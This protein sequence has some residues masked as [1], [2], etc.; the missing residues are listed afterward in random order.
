M[1]WWEVISSART[2]SNMQTTE[3]HG[4]RYW[5]RPSL[6]LFNR[7]ARSSR[8]PV[9]PLIHLISLK[10]P[11]WGFN[12]EIMIV[13]AE[14]GQPLLQGH[15]Y[16]FHFLLSFDV[17]DSFMIWRDVLLFH[18]IGFVYPTRIFII[19][20]LI[21]Q[22]QDYDESTNSFFI[23]YFNYSLLQHVKHNGC[24][25]VPLYM[26]GIN[27]PLWRCEIPN[28]YSTFRRCELSLLGSEKC[29]FLI[30]C[31]IRN[32]KQFVTIIA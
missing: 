25:I 22:I 9:G 15:L 26:F 10:P 14:R 20:I 31:T 12:N 23:N 3:F 4:S 11:M 2:N 28:E 16:R 24:V 7:C 30:L 29:N 27:I 1:N 13:S 5:L 8:K 32:L 19:E 21:W 6:R 18:H 17:E